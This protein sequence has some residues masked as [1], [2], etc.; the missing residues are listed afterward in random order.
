MVARDLAVALYTFPAPQRALSCR[1]RGC[2]GGPFAGSGGAGRAQ[3][4]GV[5]PPRPATTVN[6]YLREVAVSQAKVTVMAM[7]SGTTPRGLSHKR[8]PRSRRASFR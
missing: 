6:T 4:G 1:P 3:V 5:I 7:G 8:A 2:A